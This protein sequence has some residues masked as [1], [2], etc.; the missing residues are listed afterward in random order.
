MKKISLLVVTSLL[1]GCAL[2]DPEQAPPLYTLKS[3]VLE[4]RPVLAASLAIDMPQSE[5]S[6]NTP[7]IAVT[8][9]PYQRD[10]LA[11][12]QWPDKLPKIFQEV[13]LD[14]F[15][16]RWG[17]AYVSRVSTGLQ[18]KYILF[19]EIQDFSVYHLE[20]DHPEVHVKVAFK[21]A[22]LRARRVFA[23]HTFSIITPI[24]LFTMKGIVE[25]F[26]KGLQC[27]LTEATPWM[28]EAFL[29]ENHRTLTDN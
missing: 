23:G 24:S 11:E 22:D 4:S 3:E 19:S 25:A 7:R 27:L 12:G 10:Y 14:T 15:N 8:P 18:T 21:L 6:L 17:G 5:A 29:Q 13:L 1:S 28:E 2:L 9:S 20:R 16:Q 26:N